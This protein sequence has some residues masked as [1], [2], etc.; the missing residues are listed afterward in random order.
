MQLHGGT[1]RNSMSNYSH[2]SIINESGFTI[3]AGMGVSDLGRR[4]KGFGYIGY[5][6][7]VLGLGCMLGSFEFM[8][9]VD[10]EVKP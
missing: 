4:N 8:A 2:P 6:V 9:L 1:L 5:Q 10:C 7:Q 3:W